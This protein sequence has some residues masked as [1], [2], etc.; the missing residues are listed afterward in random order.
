VLTSASDPKRTFGT[1]ITAWTQP[2]PSLLLVGRMNSDGYEVPMFRVVS[3]FAI[4]TVV[5]LAL[6]AVLVL[7]LPRDPFRQPGV[8]WSWGLLSGY[9]VRLLDSGRYVDSNWCDIC[10]EKQSFGTWRATAN[11]YELSPDSGKPSWLLRRVE[12]GGCAR[13]E[14]PPAKRGGPP[15]YFRREG[16]SCEGLP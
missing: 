4:Y 6:T 15:V 14:G 9:T 11:G 12:R 5:A 13:L 3:W 7:A 16:D 8:S 2:L 1:S 10:Q